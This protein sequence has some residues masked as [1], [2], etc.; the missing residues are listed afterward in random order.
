MANPNIEV[1]HTKVSELHGQFVKSKAIA[2]TN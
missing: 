1:K 2:S